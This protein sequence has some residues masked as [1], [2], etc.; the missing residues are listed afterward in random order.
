MAANNEI[1]NAK[2]WL[3]GPTAQTEILATSV[4]KVFYTAPRPMIVMKAVLRLEVA[5][6]NGAAVTA[7]LVK[8]PDGT[9]VASGT[10]LLSADFNLK[11][12]AATNQTGTLVQ[13]AATIALA[14][15]DSLG[16]VFDGTLT[17]VS[18]VVTVT[19]AF[20]GLNT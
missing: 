17:D 19:L 16:I 11:G 15:G 20:N 7:M 18:G 1:Y 10:E 4:S 2:K 5:G 8:V 14:K 9:A 3:M 13:N 6:T 12:T